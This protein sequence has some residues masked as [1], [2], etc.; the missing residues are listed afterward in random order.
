MASDAE[1]SEDEFQQK[2]VPPSVPGSSKACKKTSAIPKKIGSSLVSQT[3][4]DFK[5]KFCPRKFNSSRNITRHQNVCPNN[6]NK[7][8]SKFIC[9]LCSRTFK[10]SD[11]LRAH[12][13]KPCTSTTKHEARSKCMYPG[14]EEVFFHKTNLVE[15]IRC[16]H[17]NEK[18][19]KPVEVTFPSLH[20]FLLWKEVEEEKN[21]S[22]F[23]M[24]EGKSKKRQKHLYFYCQHDGSGKPHLKEG[25]SRKT[26]RLRRGG[27]IK[28]GCLCLSHMK[29]KR[30]DGDVVSVEYFPL[31]NHRIDP[32]DFKHQPL[33]KA[34]YELIDQQLAWN[35]AP[36]DIK[37]LLEEGNFHRENRDENGQFKRNH[38]VTEKL[39]RERKRRT[40]T[41]KRLSKDDA[42]SV[43]MLYE[44]LK[45]EKYNPV[46]IYKPVNHKVVEGP[47]EASTLPDD[48]LFM[49]GIQTKSQE[50]LFKLGASKAVLVDDTHD[51]N[52]Y[53]G[54]KLVT[55]MEPDENNRSWP[56]AHLITSR[57]DAETVQYFF[58][59]L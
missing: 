12:Q 21:Y 17:Q 44:E 23:S 55:V 15:H 50:E 18:S 48:D 40:R 11:H 10:R 3:K 38:Y 57:L 22:Y 59:A 31:H 51:T 54:Y 36:S 43:Y 37:K 47:S 5:C 35:V 9:D 32:E 7:P 20:D 42:T 39:I 52:D 28:R 16:I 1:L 45:K 13:L 6:P 4:K 34:T 29:V 33:A 46:L 41:A 26:K 27:G 53:D 30:L 58:M 19:Y 56:V 2:T 49:F 14:C 25:E 8:A 24:H